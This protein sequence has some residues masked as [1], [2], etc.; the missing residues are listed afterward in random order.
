MP[1]N[2][3]S[4]KSGRFG[5]M[6]VVVSLHAGSNPL[7]AN[8]TT[9]S[10]LDTP[11]GKFVLLGGTIYVSTL[12]ADSDGTILAQITRRVAVGNGDKVL[13]AQIDMETMTL[14]ER[15]AFVLTDP[16]GASDNIF[17]PGDTIKLEVVNDS[18]SIN[19]QPANLLISFELG[20]L[21]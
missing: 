13:T 7:T 21:E 10:H 6:P 15:S 2:Y 18:A 17:L 5:V 9:S 12:A 4:P 16:P 19:T 20:Y 11:Y 8:T 3:F 14:L 1:K